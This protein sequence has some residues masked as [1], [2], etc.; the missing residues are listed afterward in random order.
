MVSSSAGRATPY[1]PSYGDRGDDSF[2]CLTTAQW[3]LSRLDGAPDARHHLGDLL[4]RNAVDL[5][6]RDHGAK[7]VGV[8]GL[9]RPVRRDRDRP[10]L[11]RAQVRVGRHHLVA[12]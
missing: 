9:D 8:C 6:V 5:G 11:T 10:A 4:H 7:Q 1:D 12:S 2:V 3:F